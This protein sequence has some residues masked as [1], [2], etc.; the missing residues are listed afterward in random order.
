[1]CNFIIHVVIFTLTLQ[2]ARATCPNIVSRHDWN[3]SS[4]TSV[5]NITSIPVPFVVIHHTYQPGFCRTHRACAAA[6][7]N[8]QNYHQNT[9]NW[10]DI[11]YHFVIGGTGEIYEGRGWDV[12][13]THAPNYNSRSVG[14]AFIGD[15]RE[16]VP[17]DEMLK[18]AKDII[19]CGVERGSIASGYKLVGHSQVK[20]TLCPGASLLEEIKT[21]PHW[22][23]LKQP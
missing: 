2:L 3:A 7:R 21:W 4:P 11:G 14:I 8:M 23:P 17:T 16:E 9:R 13:G 20:N 15:F 1:M 18:A 12:V 22:D 19:K 6:M 10:P 5:E